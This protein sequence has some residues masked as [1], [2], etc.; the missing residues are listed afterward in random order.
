VKDPN[1]LK[2]AEKVEMRLDNNL[3]AENEGGRPCRVTIRL[4]NGQTYTREAQHAKG[5]PEVPMTAEELKTKFTEC[6]R[7]AISEGSAQQ[8][9]E[10]VERLETL[11]DIRPLCELLMRAK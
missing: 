2:L 7:Q 6:A 3:K 11:E 1:V 10:C 4:K 8:V 9:M 5:S